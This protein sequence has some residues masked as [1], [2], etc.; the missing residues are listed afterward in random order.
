MVLIESQGPKWE[1]VRKC[2]QNDKLIEKAGLHA[3][4]VLVSRRACNVYYIKNDIDEQATAADRQCSAS[5]EHV[6]T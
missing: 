3:C 5:D 1:M 2:M 6:T 4:M